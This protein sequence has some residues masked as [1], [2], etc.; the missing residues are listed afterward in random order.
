MP[1]APGTRF[2]AYEI[3]DTIGKGGMGE[4]YRAHDPRLGRDIALKVL[5]DSMAKDPSGLARFEREARAVAALNNPHI[6]TIFSTE[7]SGGVRF[8]T[9]ELIEGQTLS[10][11]I[12]P[13][14]VPL[15][16]FF[17]VSMALA[18]ALSAAHSKLIT[19]RDLKPANVMVADN[20]W[21]T[22]LDFGLARGAEGRGSGGIGIED[23]ETVE[24]LTQEGTVMGTA[25]YMSP[26]QVE[27]KRIDPR[28]DIFSLGIMMHE[29]L[30][31]SRPFSGASSPLLMASILKDQPKAILELRSDVPEGVSR[32]VRR[33]LEKDPRD[34]IQ[35]AHEVL[36]ELKA[37]RSAW[38]S[39]SRSAHTAA[40]TQI[41]PT[42]ASRASKVGWALAAFALVAALSAY[43]FW[44][45]RTPSQ[46]PAPQSAADAMPSIAVLPFVDM[47]E[48][49]DQQYFSDGMSEELL[50]LLAKI[51]ALRVTSRSSAF[52]F[53]GKNTAIPEIAKSLNVANILEG[54]VRKAGNKLRITAQLIDAR[55]DA[56]IWSE[57]Y[58]RTLDDIFAVQD[59]ISAAVVA[60]LKV[61]LL[62]AMPKARQTDPRAYELFLQA[63]DVARQSKS[64]R[65][66]RSIALLQEALEIDPKY[67]AGWTRLAGTYANE[68][69][70]G[71]G[72]TRT[73]V[74]GFKLARE[75]AEKA[76]A[77]DPT[78]VWTYAALSQIAMGADSDLKAAAG[79]ME[80]AL[81]LEPR[82]PDLMF[83]AATLVQNLGRLD[84]AVALR[85]FVIAR[86]PMNPFAQFNTGVT[87][88]HAGRTDDAIAALRRSLNIAPKRIVAH[89]VIA[90]A[91]LTKHDPQGALAEIQQE[92]SD[93]WREIGLPFVYYALGKKKESDEGL[94][95][96]IATH[97]QDSAFNIA[98][99]LAFRGETDRAFEWLDKAAKYHDSGISTASFDPLLKNLHS[100]PRWLPFLRKVGQAPEQLAAIR[101]EVKVPKP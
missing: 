39:G 48:A 65:Y 51:P 100:D 17:D 33:C 87:Y 16:R 83:P 101:F 57:T 31:G 32:L 96:L 68:A 11:L 9:M 45:G 91:L 52:S 18:D 6:V 61:A 27:G 62:G 37:L 81:A 66:E 4:V 20:G 22:V 1:L 79:H 34:R 53:K 56:H 36:L 84:E 75:A 25:P 49:K 69:S 76:R 28:S 72:K 95:T 23:Q 14:G 46:A 10:R 78:F 50:N 60:K 88:L 8:M 2:G 19:H 55:T 41:L 63:D 94:A 82:N 85:E 3:R 7:E 29:M 43:V 40:Q 12:P 42:A 80:H 74:E 58:D 13:G 24:H 92:P 5:P 64:D 38:E 35:S 67:V 44:R 90:I 99:V 89:Y 47:S 54:S 15:S 26:E 86:D 70:Q 98:S 73:P 77:L 71:L 30:T 59:E 93:T 97:E 21:V